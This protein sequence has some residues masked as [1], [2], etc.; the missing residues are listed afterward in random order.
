M[1]VR[2]RTFVSC[3]WSAARRSDAK[4]L[5]N[6]AHTVVVG[7]FH[8]MCASVRMCGVCR[9]FRE[10][11]HVSCRYN[12]NACVSIINNPV[13]VHIKQSGLAS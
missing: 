6:R 8:A 5:H 7:C 2:N 1:I 13:C 12:Q 10:L 11:S 9:T 3:A 4:L